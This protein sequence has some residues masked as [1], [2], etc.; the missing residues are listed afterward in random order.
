MNLTLAAISLGLLSLTFSPITSM[1]SSEEEEGEDKVA[2][3][4][5][6]LEKAT[7]STPPRRISEKTSFSAPSTP[8]HTKQDI[9]EPHSE[10]RASKSYDFDVKLIRTHDKKQAG[11]YFSKA[12]TLKCSEVVVS[13]HDNPDIFGENSH[14]KAMDDFLV[15][16]VDVDGPKTGWRRNHLAANLFVIVN[17]IRTEQPKCLEGSILTG[18]DIFYDFSVS[19]ENK[20]LNGRRVA[21]FASSEVLA[22]EV[23]EFVKSKN[24]MPITASNLR[25]IF[26]KDNHG[27]R[28]A[29]DTIYANSDLFFNLIRKTAHREDLTILGMG[30]RYFSSYDACNACFEKIYNMRTFFQEDLTNFAARRGFKVQNEEKIP[31]YSLFYST[32]PYKEGLYTLKWQYPEEKTI[33][34]FSLTPAYTFPRGRGIIKYPIYYFELPKFSEPHGGLLFNN[35]SKQLS[36]V[37]EMTKLDPNFIYSYVSCFE[38]NGFAI[39]YTQSK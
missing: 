13:T 24:Y 26:D 30:V 27:D 2:G 9:K 37:R 1:A 18:E 4:T 36:M 12:A 39:S 22:E 3:L 5:S 8:E 21:D 14:L 7:I 38:P 29:L 20:N 11:I 33:Q 32:R 10:P 23:S 15:K 6:K 19:P 16:Q 31:F 28:L 25:P 35:R 17:D 34:S